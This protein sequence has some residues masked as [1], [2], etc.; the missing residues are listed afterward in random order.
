M[1]EHEKAKKLLRRCSNK[2]INELWQETENKPASEDN[3]T[4]RGW[5]MANWNGAT[6]RP[7]RIGF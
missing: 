3:W 1:N 7:L 4:V 2:R 5:L 6:K